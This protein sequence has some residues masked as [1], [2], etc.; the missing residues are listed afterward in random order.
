MDAMFAIG[1]EWC[2]FDDDVAAHVGTASPIM[3]PCRI[4]P[5]PTHAQKGTRTAD[6]ARPHIV[7]PRVIDRWHSTGR[8]RGQPE[9]DVCLPIQRVRAMSRMLPGT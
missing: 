5:G 9:I 8:V 6:V 3:P 2:P 7:Q 4:R 1:I